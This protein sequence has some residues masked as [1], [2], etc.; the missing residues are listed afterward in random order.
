MAVKAGHRKQHDHGGT[1]KAY[2]GAQLPAQDRHFSNRDG[3]VWDEA[4]DRVR[5]AGRS[6][7][8]ALLYRPDKALQ[9]TRVAKERVFRL[10]LCFPIG[11]P[12]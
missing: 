10:A 5:K 9:E 12:G 7:I 8:K 4:H 1:A 3:A 6:R 2:G 11:K